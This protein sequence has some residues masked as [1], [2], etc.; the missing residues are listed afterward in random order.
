VLAVAED[1][2]PQ[3][4]PDCHMVAPVVNDEGIRNE[5]SERAAIYLCAPP[6]EGWTSVWPRLRHLSS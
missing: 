6:V 5:E 2:P 3:L 4:L 1:G